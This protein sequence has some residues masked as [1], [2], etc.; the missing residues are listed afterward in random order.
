MRT[1][2]GKDKKKKITIGIEDF[3]EII[4]TDGY[5]VDKTLMIEELIRNNAKVTLFTRP[6]RFGKTLNQSM[7]RRFFE[8]ERTPEGETIENGALFD[9]LAIMRCNAEIRKHQQRYPVISL[10]LK[11]AKQPDFKEAYGKLCDEIASEFRRHRYV[12]T[13]GSLALEQKETYQRIMAG[14]GAYGD[15]SGAL[16]FLTECLYLHHKQNVVLLIDEYDVPLE[17]AYLRGYY[18]EM[19]DFIR[20]LFESALKT[21]PYLYKGVITGCLRISR[22][23]IFT[24]LNNLEVHSI[25]SPNY[26]DC[27]GFTE[28]ETEK[29]MAYYDFSDKYPELKEWYDGYRFG[30]AEIYNPWSVLSYIRMAQGDRNY[31]PRAYWSNTSSNSI[32]RELVQDADSDT[33]KDLEALMNGGTIEKPIHEEITYDAIHASMDDLW[34]F[35]FFTGYLKAGKQRLVQETIYL[36]MS[37]PNKEVKSVYRQSISQWFKEKLTHAQTDILI[38]ALEKGECEAAEAFISSQLMETISYYD[39]AENFYHG[40]LAGILT[41][42]GRYRVTSNRESGNGR[43]DLVLTEQKFMGR[44]ILLE[45]KVAKNFRDMQAKCEEGLEQIENENYAKSLED[46]GYQ[47]ILEYAV[48]FFKKGCMVKKK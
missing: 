3:K 34:N 21:N 19:I 2:S 1:S 26:A 37:I 42:T 16:R 12:L 4:E 18:D 20:S 29:M 28:T 13:D 9:D 32:V 30:N 24:G 35:L 47:E 25:L 41:N 14:K 5:F 15:Y 40:F 45:L 33:R 31:L 46:D 6:R 48:C 44:A 23:S 22:E 11:S 27:F 8:D 10:S 39:Y 17:N 7:L 43:P 38:E 36:E